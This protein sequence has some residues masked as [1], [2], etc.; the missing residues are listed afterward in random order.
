MSLDTLFVGAR[1]VDGTGAPWY[2]GSVGV[3]D[4]EITV[5]EQ[6]PD[7]DLDAAERVDVDG[8][9]LCPGFIDTHSHSDLRLFEDPTL[10]PKTRQGITTEVLG[11]DGFSMAPLYR[12][13]AAEDWAE[14]LS[15]LAGTTDREWTWG[16]SART[17]TPSRTTASHRT[18]G[19]WWARG[20]SASR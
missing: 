12:D 7:P 19:R 9:V 11:Q 10:A 13:G 4:G 18:S 2:R 20:R 1:V 6:R 14:Q 17:S 5:V 3:E 15:G 16:A 8:Y